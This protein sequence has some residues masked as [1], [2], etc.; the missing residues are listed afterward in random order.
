MRVAVQFAD[1]DDTLGY[2]G[3]RNAV[4]GVAPWSKSR[5]FFFRRLRRRFAEFDLRKQ[6]S[7]PLR[8]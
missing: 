1:L 7:M 4:R 8:A 5:S 6:A 3:A 2:M